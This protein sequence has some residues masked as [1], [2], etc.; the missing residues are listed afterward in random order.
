MAKPKMSS[1]IAELEHKLC[2]KQ[3]EIAK[4]ETEL[5]ETKKRLVVIAAENESI[6]MDKKWLQQMHS[7]VLQA[8][9]YK[10]QNGH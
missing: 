8:M 10:A 6:R 4:L 1:T 3:S 7:H 2:Y 9:I 5:I